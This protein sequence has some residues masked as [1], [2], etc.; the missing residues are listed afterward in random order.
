MMRPRHEPTPTT[1]SESR[2]QLRGDQQVRQTALLVL[3]MILL[4]GCVPPRVLRPSGSF[5]RDA[6]ERALRPG[7]STIVGQAFKKTVGGDVKY[8]AGNTVYLFPLT[9]YLVEVLQLLPQKDAFTQIQFDP[10][11]LGYNRTTVADGEGRFKFPNL[12]PGHYRIETTITWGIPTGHGIET[13]GGAAAAVVT[14]PTDGDTVEV[15]LQ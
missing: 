3:A 5:D 11:V 14:V 6:A 2:S 12:L 10:A 7:K 1:S 9:P 13:T 15:I 8:G 4:S